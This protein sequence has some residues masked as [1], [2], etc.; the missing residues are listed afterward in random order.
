MPSKQNHFLTSGTLYWNKDFALTVWRQNMQVRNALHL[1]VVSNAANDIT[2]SFTRMIPVIMSLKTHYREHNRMIS[3]FQYR[4]STNT[5]ESE[6]TAGGSGITSVSYVT[7][8][9]AITSNSVLMM[10]V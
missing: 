10:T 3:W 8:P 5:K 1:T 7:A 6:N 4:I 2:P 9:E